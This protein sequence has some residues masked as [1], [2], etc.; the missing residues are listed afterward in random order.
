VWRSLR[1]GARPSDAEGGAVQFCELLPSRRYGG[2]TGHQA[3]SGFGDP[4]IWCRMGFPFPA[5][6]EVIS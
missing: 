2:I 5:L 3:T 4:M 6:I 1:K